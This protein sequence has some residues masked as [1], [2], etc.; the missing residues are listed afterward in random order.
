MKRDVFL[1]FGGY[2][3]QRYQRPAVEDIEL[4]MRISAAGHYIILDPRIQAKH[5]KRWT[6]WNLLKT[7]IF[8]RGVPWIRLMLQ[9]GAMIG[10]L[11]V[12]PVQRLSVPLA[13]LPLLGVLPSAREPTMLAVAAVTALVVTL[14]NL[15]LYHFYLKRRGLWFV[16][17]GILMHWVYLLAAV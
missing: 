15:N 4:G 11:N 13:Y 6:F 2:D 7:D 16:L 14:L 5:L 10:T 1:A 12:T 17:R 9:S 8:H 3:Q